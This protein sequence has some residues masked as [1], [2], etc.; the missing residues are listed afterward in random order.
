M[1][2]IEGIK[3]REIGIRVPVL[4]A[5]HVYGR[6]NIRSVYFRMND[7]LILREFMEFVIKILKVREHLSI[8]Y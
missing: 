5:I 3:P 7:S 1:G 2:L 6:N 4:N 8:K